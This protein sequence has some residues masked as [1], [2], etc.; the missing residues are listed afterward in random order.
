MH[1]PASLSFQIHLSLQQQ[2][3]LDTTSGIRIWLP[4]PALFGTHRLSAGWLE[5]GLVQGPSWH[6]ASFP[7][8]R[9]LKQNPGACQAWKPW[10]RPAGVGKVETVWAGR[11]PVQGCGPPPGRGQEG[12]AG[13]RL[14]RGARQG[15]GR[16]LCL[17]RDRALEGVSCE[18]R[19]LKQ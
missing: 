17:R 12:S 1:F 11:L 2:S 19:V 5:E 18:L 13:A 9:G 15:P 4:V 14:S 3:A 16:R 8:L 10:E 7:R 6:G